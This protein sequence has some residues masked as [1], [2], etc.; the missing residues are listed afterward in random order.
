PPYDRPGTVAWYEGGAR[1]GADGV[2]LLVGHVDTSRRPAVFHRLSKVR[3]GDRVSVLGADGSVARFAVDDVEVVDRDRFD[4][5]RVYGR[6]VPGRAEL[7]LLTCGGT[8]DR[9]AGV[10]SANVVVSA[11]LTGGPR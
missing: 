3:R 10:Y 7:R 9:A 1:P 4:A 11:Y 5:R 8:F 6:R 2:A